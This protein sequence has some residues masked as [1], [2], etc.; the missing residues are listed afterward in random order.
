VATTSSPEGFM[1][2]AV[3]APEKSASARTNDF[4]NPLRGKRSSNFK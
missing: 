3:K 2:Q 1:L 4:L